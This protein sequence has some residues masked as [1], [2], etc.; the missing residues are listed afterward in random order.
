MLKII[1][2]QFLLSYISRERDKVKIFWSKGKKS[3]RKNNERNKIPK[4]G[5]I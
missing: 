1:L 5:D 3:L 2:P 4:G